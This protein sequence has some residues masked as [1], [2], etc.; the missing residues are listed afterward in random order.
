[1]TIALVEWMVEGYDQAL[2]RLETETASG[3]AG[4]RETFLPLF[5]ALNWAASIDLY[6][7]EDKKPIGNDLLTAVRFARNR[8]HHQWALALRRFDSPG[9]PMIHLATSSSRIVGPPPGFW[10]Y[11]VDLDEL[12]PGKPWPAG[13]EAYSA[14]LAGKGADT[15]LEG[16][17]PV[18]EALSG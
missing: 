14:L 13:E 11:W 16:L 10:W 1:M 2:E 15:T 17:R 7:I 4:E 3:D 8:A 12:P 18:L 5:E 6:F 9:V